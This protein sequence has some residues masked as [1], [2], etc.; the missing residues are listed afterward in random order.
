MVCH[1]SM[2]RTPLPQKTWAAHSAPSANAPTRFHKACKLL[3]KVNVDLLILLFLGGT[4]V[5]GHHVHRTSVL[6]RAA[7]APAILPVCRQPKGRP[8]E[9][10]VLAVLA[11]HVL[12]CR[13]CQLSPTQCRNCNRLRLLLLW[14]RL[15][16]QRNFTNAITYCQINKS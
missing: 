12:S 15:L 7:T 10:T 3:K 6:L 8:R 5:L 9:A 4:T 2:I 13:L 14:L 11:L 1:L 16:R